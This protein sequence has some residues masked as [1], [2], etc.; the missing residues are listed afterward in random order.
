MVAIT[1]I[2][3]AVIGTFVLGLGDQV[4]ESAPNAQFSAEVTNPEPTDDDPFMEFVHQ[5]GD[6]VDPDTLSVNLAGNDG[7]AEIHDLDDGD[8]SDSE[9]LSAGDTVEVRISG[10]H[11]EDDTINE[12]STVGLIWESGDR[13][14]TLRAFDLPEDIEVQED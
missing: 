10:D 6:S 7:D 8:F 14:S 12:D 13:S 11:N 2:L 9:S 5:G 3:A 1:V 4:G